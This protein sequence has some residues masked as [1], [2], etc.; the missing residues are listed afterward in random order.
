MQRR[1]AVQG[2][3]ILTE[4]ILEHALRMRVK[5]ETSEKESSDVSSSPPGSATPALDDT[6]IS[7]VGENSTEDDQ[8]PSHSK[9][10]SD[11]HSVDTTLHTGSSTTVASSANLKKDA[12]TKPL[13][14]VLL[15][16]TEPSTVTNKPKIDTKNILGKVNNLI[17]TDLQNITE[18]KEALRMVIQVP[19]L[20]TL[21]T[22]FLY[23]ILGWR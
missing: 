15:T 2:E 9:L 13:A 14:P 20:V 21:G 1:Q 4:I 10:S 3:A 23:N 12:S 11:A 19:I 8:Q 7:E 22:I 6:T 17:T 18:G 5:A 16:S